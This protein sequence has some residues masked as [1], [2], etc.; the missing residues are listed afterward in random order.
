MKRCPIT[1]QEITEG[2][3]SKA[4]LRKL[5]PALQSLHPFPYDRKA[6]L[7]ESQK[8]MTKM[9]I[10]GVHPKMSARL[11]IKDT[12][13][14]IVD[15]LGSYILKPELSDYP[16]VPQNEDVTM[17]MAEAAGIDV[18]IHGLI[19]AQDNSMLYFI[20]RFDRTGKAGKIHV[21]DFAQVAGMTRDTK[22]D[23]SM[24]KAATL[25][26]TYCTFP[27]VEK[28]KFFRRILFSWLVGNEDMHLKNFSFIH[29]D[30]KI[31][32]SPAYDLLNTTIVLTSPVEEMALPLK[33]KKSHFSYDIFF[34]Y[35]GKERLGLSERILS[36]IEEDFKKVYG[37]WKQLLAISFL[38]SEKKKAY[39]DILSKR[40]S[41]LNWE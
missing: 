36:T 23:Y 4:G 12:C 33:G 18:P 15:R 24:E 35:F 25:L 39:Q 6:Q 11:S 14:K 8:R 16:E 3:Y 2:L 13:F 41:I 38:S 10:A 31:E 21:E 40:R 19:Y 7:T 17:R 26:D 32:L 1:Y 30:G 28:V 20:R 9:S 5:N 34:N 29:R 22:Y 37:S 27:M